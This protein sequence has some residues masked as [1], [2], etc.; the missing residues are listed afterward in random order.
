MTEKNRTKAQD[1]LDVFPLGELT[2]RS[3]A[4]FGKLP[5]M[6]IW[7]NGGYVEWTYSVLH[8]KVK[9]IAG[10]L[11]EQEIQPGDHIAILGDNSPEWEASYLGIQKAGGICIPIDRMLPAAGIRFILAESKARLLFSSTKFIKMLSEVE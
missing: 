10:W 3:T 11:F 6:R 7:Q 8:Q 4:K 5:V 2:D 1:E 9:A